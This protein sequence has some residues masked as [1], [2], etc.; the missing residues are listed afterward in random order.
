MRTLLGLS[1][2]AV[3][4]AAACTIAPAPDARTPDRSA[5][6]HADYAGTYAAGPLATLE[7]GA[8]EDLIS[9]VPP[10]WG[11]KPYLRRVDGET[12]AFVLPHPEPERTLTFERGPDGTVTA[13]VMANVDGDHDGATFRRLA[14]DE[15]TPAVLFMDR[16]PVAAAEAALAEPGLALGKVL[17][18]VERRFMRHPSRHASTAA[19][20]ETLAAAHPGNARIQALLGHARVAVGDRAA[21]RAAFDRASALDPH[22]ETAREGLRLLDLTEPAPG[23]GYRAVLPY[24]LADAFAPPSE[25][26]NAEVR[27]M[28]TARNLAARDVETLHKFELEHAGVVFDAQIVRHRG[29]AGT[30]VGAVLVPEG[31]YEP[32][33]VVIDAR[34]VDPSYSP[35]DLADPPNSLVALGSAAEGFVILAPAYRGNRL[36]ADGRKFATEGDPSE[37]WDGATDDALAFL[38]A[39]LAVTPQADPDRVAVL[40][41]SRGGTV[42]LLAGIRDRRVGLVLDVVGPVDQFS[43]QDPHVGWTWAELLAADMADG[44]PPPMRDDSGQKFDHFFDRGESLAAVRRRMLASSPLYFAA[45]LPETH[46]WYGADDTS[47]P[48]ANAGALEARLRS[49]GRLGGDATVTVFPDRG[50]DTDPYLLARDVAARLSVWAA[51]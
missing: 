19:F 8:V 30:H 50:H 22:N 46:A 6:V 33:P 17:A 2:V 24:R 12:F 5:P 39:A 38:N 35:L 51:R 31:A 40:G 7:I 28:W 20:L 3:V 34:G 11:A 4:C 9:A 16:R 27:A 36:L 29:P 48:L 43:A 1:L 47:V 45:D 10:F 14:P 37:A 49:L 32:L 26:E 25:A 21:A 23:E 13:V 41:K 42:A 18:T 15:T 44:E